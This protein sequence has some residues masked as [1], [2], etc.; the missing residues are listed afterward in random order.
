[1]STSKHMDKICI[2]ALAVML[3]ATV[4]L[5]SCFGAAFAKESTVMGYEKKLF[6]TSYVHKIDI[7]MGDW[8]SFIET[9][10]NEEYSP[11]TVLVDGEKYSNIAIRAKGNTS[12]SSV[13]SMGSERYSFKLEFDQYEKG[14][15]YH[16]LDKLCLN[17]LIQDN[18]MMKDYLVYRLMNE[19]DVDSPLCS[20]VYITV[21]GEDWGLYLAVEGVEDSFL[22]RN[23]G[24]D[25]GELYK[26]DSMS[27]GG[28]RGNGREFDINS[29]DFGGDSS[30]D[31]E[32]SSESSG[33]PADDFFGGNMPNVPGGDFSFGDFGGGNFSADNMPQMPDGNFPGGS[34]PG[35]N[36]NS[37]GSGKTG[38]DFSSDNTPQF[39]GGNIPGGD[40]SMEDFDIKDLPDIFSDGGSISESFSEMFGGFG[41]GSDDVKLKYV[42]DD[43]DSYPNIF[44]NAKT[45]ISKADKERLISALKNLSDYT[46]LENTLD[47]EEVLRYFVVHNFS[48]NGDSYTGS[49]IHNYYLH[50][51]DG[52][53]GMIPWDYNLAFGTFM[54]GNASSSV[55]SSID[56][57]VSGGDVNDRP[58][59][60]W[61]FSD[62]EYI[63]Q[64]HALYSEF[65]EEWINSGKLQ[66]MIDSTVEMISPY[67]EKDPTKFCTSEEFEAG[68][69]AI[70]EFVSLRGEAVS[71]QLNGDTAK[72][73]VNGL[74][75]SDM[76]SM[77]GSMGGFSP[78]SGKNPSGD[79]TSVIPEEKSAESET[80]GYREVKN[81]EYQQEESTVPDSSKSDF[82]PKNLPDNMGGKNI[83]MSDFGAGKSGNN[84]LSTVISL[85]VSVAVLVIGLIIVLKKKI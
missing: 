33:F 31:S 39:P 19:F 9:C 74:S 26:P 30:S 51:S 52:K 3:S 25:S 21:N 15:S 83:S 65:V 18:T 29:F 40:F 68:V 61:I 66:E 2:A 72:V 53:L 70:K 4:I 78:D 5:M 23:Y 11:C 41:M 22:M 58:M 32:E 80:D 56:S 75:I 44:D 46:N 73:E 27:F 79:E 71:K 10:E 7:V 49:M 50:E 81:N 64:Y 36:Q 8:D 43:P 62:E 35:S 24:S 77:G 57:L 47:M 48:V 82:S 42:D 12:L 16:G 20:F 38:L 69:T 13:K 14:K 76:G 28:G 59:F 54:G 55:N 85:G 17:N 84:A 45:D 60:G 6:D 63:E 67:V 37:T 1:M 34:M